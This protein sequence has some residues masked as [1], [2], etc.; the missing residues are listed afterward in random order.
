L[1]LTTHK[2]IFVNGTFDLIHPGHLDLLYY[3]AIHNL[4]YE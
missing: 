3:V 4:S 1:D 2:R